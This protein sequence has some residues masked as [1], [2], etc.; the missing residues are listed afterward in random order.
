MTTKNIAGL[1]CLAS[2]CA[3]AIWVEYEAISRFG[4]AFIVIA[5]ASVLAVLLGALFRAPEGYEGANGLHVR[6]GNRRFGPT[7]H[8]RLSTANATRMDVTLRAT[9]SRKSTT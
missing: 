3:G 1:I 8:V 5:A 2:F 4:G 7:R 9:S 6:P